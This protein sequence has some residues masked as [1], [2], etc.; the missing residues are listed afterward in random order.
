MTRRDPAVG[1]VE[2]GMS[3]SC[4]AIALLRSDIGDVTIYEKADDV[5]NVA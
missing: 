3:G 1:V 5:P 4:I 2:P